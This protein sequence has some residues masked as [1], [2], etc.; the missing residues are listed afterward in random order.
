VLGRKGENSDRPKIKHAPKKK[1]R[2]EVNYGVKQKSN[3]R[4]GKPK[5]E[6]ACILL[7]KIQKM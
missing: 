3:Y 2:R 4:K 5:K 1:P 6:Q 7:Q